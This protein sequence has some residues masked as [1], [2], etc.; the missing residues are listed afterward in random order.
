MLQRGRGDRQKDRR[1]EGKRVGGGD[2]AKER[3]SEK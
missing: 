2:Q 3:K 1:G